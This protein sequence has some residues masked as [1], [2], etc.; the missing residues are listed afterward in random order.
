MP[1]LGNLIP[2]IQTHA[3]YKAVIADNI[4]ISTVQQDPT[5]KSTE[6]YII[7]RK[8][9]SD[10]RIHDSTHEKENENTV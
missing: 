5:E 2:A 4:F 7:L 3:Q 8:N 9:T 1:L 6:K 10:N